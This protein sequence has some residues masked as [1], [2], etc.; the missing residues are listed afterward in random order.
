MTTPS[1][2]SQIRLRPGYFAGAYTFWG[3]ENREAA[4]RYV[5]GGELLGADAANI[6]LKACDASANPYL[7]LAAVIASGLA[8][9]ADGLPLPRSDRR[10]PGRLVGG[11]ARRGGR[12]AAPDRSRRAGGGAAGARPGR[13][14]A[15]PRA[16]R[17]VPRRPAQRRRLGRRQGPRRDRRRT[18]V[19]LLTEQRADLPQCDELC[20]AFWAANALRASGFARHAGGGGARRRERPVA[21]RRAVVAA[22]RRGGPRAGRRAAGG[23]AVGDVGAR[24]RPGGR[25]ALGRRLSA[26]PASGEFTAGAL[27]ALLEGIDAVAVIA[28]VDTAALWAPDVTEAEVERYVASGDDQGPDNDW[29]VGHFVAIAGTPRTAPGDRRQLRARGR[30]TCSRRS[31]WRP[32]SRGRG[33]LVVTADPAAARARVEAAGLERRA[34]GQRLARPRSAD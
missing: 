11:G 9:I 28:N 6:E 23:R 5:P 15:R 22:A 20:G 8:G 30:C 32:R 16:H 21:A 34:L 12:P 33:L 29:Q 1:V 7:A 18:P 14:C 4:L 24:R 27:L 19:A 2:P 25:G 31:A 13:G 3:V 17:S 10:G 26:V